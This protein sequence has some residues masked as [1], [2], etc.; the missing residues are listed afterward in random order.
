MPPRRKTTSTDGINASQKI[1]TGFTTKKE[2]K[3]E[4]GKNEG[5]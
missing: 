5:T 1:S 2:P 4:V 3:V